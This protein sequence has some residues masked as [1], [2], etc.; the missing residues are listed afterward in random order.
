MYD[1]N[2]ENGNFNTAL[3]SMTYCYFLCRDALKYFLIVWN[4]L[5]MLYLDSL[6][7]WP[8]FNFWPL[9]SLVTVHC[10]Y[11]DTR[12]TMFY[13]SFNISVLYMQ[14]FF[15]SSTPHLQLKSFLFLYMHT[16]QPLS[17]ILGHQTGRPGK[18]SLIME[19]NLMNYEKLK[20]VQQAGAI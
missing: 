12:V 17:R 18:R 11:A 6:L 1:H 3:A 15:N 19:A 9:C 4:L 7:P 20:T 8:F 16:C 5:F 14:F 10:S 2:L 13:E